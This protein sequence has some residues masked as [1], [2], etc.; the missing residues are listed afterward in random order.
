MDLGFVLEMEQTSS[1]VRDAILAA[2][3]F[4]DVSA[5]V[6]EYVKGCRL[7]FRAPY[8]LTSW[9]HAREMRERLAV[10]MGMHIMSLK[11][12]DDLVDNDMSTDRLSLGVG[13]L[14]LSHLALHRMCGYL[15]PE[16]LLALLT[17]SMAALC[18]SQIL[19]TQ[20]PAINMAQWRE[21]ADGY[22]GGF[23][24]IYSKIAD[25][26]GEARLYPGEAFRFAARC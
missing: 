12:G 25:L 13:S 10:D 22:G 18:R 8:L 2:L 26:L 4:A 23:L 3:E 15:D 20:N 5:E 16:A 9:Q 21:H 24:R 6:R 7:Y 17:D 14:H 11:L 19:A 1:K